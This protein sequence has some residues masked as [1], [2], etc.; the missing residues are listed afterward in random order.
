[1]RIAIVGAA[2]FIGT[3][4]HRALLVS[5]IDVLPISSTASAFDLETGIIVDAL[6]PAGPLDAVVYLSQ[7]P[8]YRDVPQ[9]GAHLWGVNVVS[10]LK[11]AEWAR[12]SNAR[13]FVYA[14]SGNVYEP[15]FSP[16]RE[17]APLRR[18]NWYALSKVQAEEA[19]QVYGDELRVTCARLFGVYGAGQHGKLVPNLIDS[20]RGHRTIRLQPHP[21]DPRDDGGVRVSLT[22]VDDVVQVMRQLAVAGGPRALNIAGPDTLSVR[23]IATRVGRGLAIEPSFA[24]E[25]RPREGDLVADRTRLC[26]EWAGPFRRFDETLEPLLGLH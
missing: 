19:L 11:A 6:L 23:D 15:G 17:D 2:G 8:R 14:S 10:A 12:R 16:L 24:A 25:T 7:S 3:H 26:A 20:V 21:A 22:H 13:R 1:M 5:G 9:Q 4:L 18:D